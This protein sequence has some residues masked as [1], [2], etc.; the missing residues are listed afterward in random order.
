M[1][2][3]PAIVSRN[4]FSE[5]NDYGCGVAD[6]RSVTWQQLSTMTPND[7]ATLLPSGFSFGY[8]PAIEHD[9]TFTP[10]DKNPQSFM[11]F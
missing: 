10:Y 5:I 9:D 1:L 11:K 4:L 2:R 3:I 7:M 8:L 6:N